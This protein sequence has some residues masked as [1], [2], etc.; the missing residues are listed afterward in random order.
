MLHLAHPAAE[1]VAALSAGYAQGRALNILNYHSTP[2]A[3]RDEYR[4][5]LE[6]CASR[7]SSFDQTKLDDWFA[8][9]YVAEKPPLI[10]VLFEGFRDNYD[11]ILP[12]VEEFGFRA[13]FFVPSHFL[14]VPIAEQ[15]SFAKA[16]TLHYP[17]DDYPGDR[18][19][20]SWAEARDAADR[21]HVF[22]CHSR[23]H[24]EVDPETADDVL[25]S[26][27]IE[28]KREMD[29][30]LNRSVEIFCWLHGAEV[31][32]NPRADAML[33]KAGYRFLFSNFKLQKLQ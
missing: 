14:N 1:T 31:G 23:T 4:R 16:H 17:C 19:V 24:A 12:I 28:A 9:T 3:C 6:A 27:I 15:R 18:I 32:V 33:R 2:R 22:A 20:M 5:Q 25:H 30:G 29:E 11:V 7:F 8:G 21:G 13:W 26:E 10:P